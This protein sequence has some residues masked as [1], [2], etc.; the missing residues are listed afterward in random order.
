MRN[1][2]NRLNKRDRK[3]QRSYESSSYEK[4]GNE[5]QYYVYSKKKKPRKNKKIYYDGIDD[6][7]DDVDDNIDNYMDDKKLS[8][9]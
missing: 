2:P 9:S 7:N 4:T 5:K 6:D 8:F 1:F 3:Y